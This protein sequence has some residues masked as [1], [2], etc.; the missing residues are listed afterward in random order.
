MIQVCY[1]YRALYFS[2][3]YI[4]SPLR[5]SDIRFQR[6]GTPDLGH[7][8]CADLCYIV[9]SIPQKKDER[10]GEKNWVWTVQRRFSKNLTLA[11]L[12]INRKNGFFRI[13]LFLRGTVVTAQ[14]VPEG[15][16]FCQPMR[17]PAC[18]SIHLLSGLVPSV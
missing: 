2:Y 1:I 13:L 15:F 17:A 11:G 6:L 18:L 9:G 14:R 4:S 5:S 10:H 7:T 3:D 12:Q 8:P 16:G